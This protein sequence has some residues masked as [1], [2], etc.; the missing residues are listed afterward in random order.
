MR[1]A[2]LERKTGE[3]E[4]E[5]ELSLDGTGQWELDTGIGFFDHMLSHIAA[6]GLIDV[7]L[8]VAGDLGL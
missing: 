7:R 8:R 4:I 2:Y 6:H 1:T 5:L 3:T